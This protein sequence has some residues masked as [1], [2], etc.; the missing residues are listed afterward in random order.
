MNATV[1]GSGGPGNPPTRHS[2]SPGSTGS[3]VGLGTSEVCLEREEGRTQQACGQRD[4]GK[5]GAFAG[6]G[7]DASRVRPHLD[8]W[9]VEK[10]DH[11]V[12]PTRACPQGAGDARTLTSRGL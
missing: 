10:L 12:H 2:T 5:K 7:S 1:L 8:A 6:S 4:H 9:C 11:N 3:K